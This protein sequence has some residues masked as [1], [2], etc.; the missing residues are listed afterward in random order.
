MTP[1]LFAVA[2]AATRSSVAVISTTERG[3]AGVFSKAAVDA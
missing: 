2:S 1:T 3:A